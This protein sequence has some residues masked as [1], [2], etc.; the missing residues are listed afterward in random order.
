MLLSMLLDLESAPYACQVAF[1]MIFAI[2]YKA[3]K[4]PHLHHTPRQP[5]HLQENIE[6]VADHRITQ[7]VLRLTDEL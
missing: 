2:L 1:N 5:L 7:N 4:R 3:T 6:L